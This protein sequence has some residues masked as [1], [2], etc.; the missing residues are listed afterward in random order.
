VPRLAEVVVGVVDAIAGGHGT[1]LLDASSRNGLSLFYVFFSL[2]FV[3]LY[4]FQLHNQA[5]LFFLLLRKASHLLYKD[6]EREFDVSDGKGMYPGCSGTREKGNKKERRKTMKGA[7]GGPKGIRG[8][9][10]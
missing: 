7:L 6:Q 3:Y 9:R 5:L 1:P 2:L 10:E 8:G 4:R